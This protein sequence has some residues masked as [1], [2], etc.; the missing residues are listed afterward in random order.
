VRSLTLCIPPR[1]Y[2]HHQSIIGSLPVP[3]WAPSSEAIDLN[4]GKEGEEKKGGE[5]KDEDAMD[6]VSVHVR[7]NL[8]LRM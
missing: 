3:E 7:T 8:L 1:V 5:D 6:V 2:D 4:E